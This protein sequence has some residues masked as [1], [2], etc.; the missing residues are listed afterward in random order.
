MLFTLGMSFWGCAPHPKDVLLTLGTLILG[1]CSSSWGCHPGEVLLILGT[2]SSFQGHHPED[3]IIIIPG[4][5]FQG[6]AP[7]PGYM[8]L[9]PR[10]SLRD[11]ILGMCFSP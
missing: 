10:T 8:L 11:I 9:I 5:S 6:R 4:V 7:H 3:V 1:M 2:C